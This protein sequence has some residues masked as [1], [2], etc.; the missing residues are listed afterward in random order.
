ME[1]S[2]RML[3]T[4]SR[5]WISSSVSPSLY[6]ESAKYIAPWWLSSCVLEFLCNTS[7]WAASSTPVQRRHSNDVEYYRRSYEDRYLPIRKVRFDFLLD[8]FLIFTPL[9]CTL[10]VTS[11]CQTMALWCLTPTP[12]LKTRQMT[13]RSSS[14][15][16]VLLGALKKP[17]RELL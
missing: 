7:F 2:L 9:S 4:A 11:A 3:R 13:P 1:T 10:D 14:S 8:I 16:M 12:H 5:C 6:G 15:Y 17:I